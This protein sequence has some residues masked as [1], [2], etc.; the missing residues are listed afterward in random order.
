M[1]RSD[2][3]LWGYQPHFR[4]LANNR[5]RS[6]FDAL[7][8]ALDPRVVLVGIAQDLEVTPAIFVDAHKPEE[9]VPHLE[10][11]ERTLSR[12]AA[13]R[14]KAN[15][16]L[17]IGGPPGT[18]DRFERRVRLGIASRAVLSHLAGSELG[19][20]NQVWAGLAQRVGGY[21]ITPVLVLA[22]SAVER[23]PR[24][25]KSSGRLGTH[26]V[27]LLDAA[28]RELMDRCSLALRIPNA[29]EDVSADLDFGEDDQLVRRAASH[30]MYVP[31]VA[32]G[33]IEGLGQLF[34][35]CETLSAQAYERS[36]IQATL[37]IAERGHPNVRVMLELADRV[38]LKKA[39]AARKLLQM[40]GGG[41]ALLSDGTTLW[42]MGRLAGEYDVQREDLFEVRFR[43]HLQWE[44]RHGPQV[45]FEVKNRTPRLPE[46]PLDQERFAVFFRR[47]F[48]SAQAS[49]VE[50]AW[51]LVSA[52]LAVGHGTTLVISED[53]HAEAER[54]AAQG[55]RIV[56]VSLDADLVCA[57]TSIDGALLLDQSGRCHAIGV[58]LDWLA[59][60]KGHPS[61]GS[62]FNSALRYVGGRRGVIAVVISDDASIDLLPDMRPRISRAR[63]LAALEELRVAA[64]DARGIGRLSDAMTALYALEFYLSQ[65]ECA[66][67][68]RLRREIEEKNPPRDFELRI[69]Y[70]DLAPDPEMGPSYF[71]D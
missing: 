64:S 23:H 62:R 22:R 43:G 48:P 60:G 40:S 14:K 15:A 49:D 4:L 53:A 5:A 7:D 8:A 54:L 10:G 46:K 20:A 12:V 34:P 41:L 65:A 36:E 37:V 29:G 51:N 33:E 45:L 26:A 21:L 61:R 68:N 39:R 67:V 25:T 55:T 6:V 59:A 18:A 13:V 50:T 16:D 24:L 38:D 31:V 58:I 30:L 11:L 44:L 27:S 69:V 3:V 35:T 71:D 66:E 1:V 2:F 32:G 57:A 47:M 52:A 9:F 63:V 42:G 28:A 56:P 17:V 19:R 70:Q